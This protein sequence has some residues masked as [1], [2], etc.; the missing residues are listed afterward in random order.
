LTGAT[1]KRRAADGR[2]GVFALFSLS[3]SL[4]LTPFF[5]FFAII[6][7]GVIRASARAFVASRS[8]QRSPFPILPVSPIPSRFAFKRR[9]T[10]KNARGAKISR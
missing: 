5:A 7:K 8:A 1:R 2:S 3:P 4:V 10:P 6:N 9:K